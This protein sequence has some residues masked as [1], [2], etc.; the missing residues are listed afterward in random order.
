MYALLDV[1]LRLKTICTYNI[2]VDSPFIMGLLHCSVLR[3]SITIESLMGFQ[4]CQLGILAAPGGTT[5]GD[6]CPAVSSYSYEEPLVPIS[7]AGPGEH[8]GVV[9]HTATGAGENPDPRQRLVGHTLC[10]TR[11]LGTL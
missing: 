6:G 4:F 9:Q 3:I 10:A 11:G 1:S 8:D 5:T 2:K 7:M